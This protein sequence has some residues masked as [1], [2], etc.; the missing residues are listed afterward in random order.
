M[1]SRLLLLC[2]F[3][4]LVFVYTFYSP[5]SSRTFHRLTLYAQSDVLEPQSDVVADLPIHDIIKEI[6]AINTPIN[7]TSSKPA[8]DDNE[9]R[10]ISCGSC[11][12]IYM[13]PSF[14]DLERAIGTRGTRVKCSVCEKLWFQ[15]LERVGKM[16]SQSSTLPISRERADEMRRFIRDNNWVR[17]QKGD[18]VDLFVGNVPY[19]YDEDDICKG[20]VLNHGVILL[21]C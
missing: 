8:N 20:Y 17:S 9:P 18:K 10:Y 11:K 7:V 16:D 19:D 12:S 14:K 15:S 3:A 1:V 4:Q 5:S 21:F 2:I 6:P 13:Y